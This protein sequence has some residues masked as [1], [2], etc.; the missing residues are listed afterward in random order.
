MQRWIHLEDGNQPTPNSLDSAS[1]IAISPDGDPL[2]AG[3]LLNEN[4]TYDD[5]T[6]VKLRASSGDASPIPMAGVWLQLV[7]GALLLLLVTT[8]RFSRAQ[9]RA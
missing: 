1:A 7:L 6:I 4:T 5:P 3:I 2:A 8:P 9:P